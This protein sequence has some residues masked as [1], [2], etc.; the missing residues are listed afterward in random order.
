LIAADGAVTT[1]S[2][3]T[4]QGSPAPVLTP[5]PTTAS[6]PSLSRTTAP[7]AGG[8]PGGGGPITTSTQ[9]PFVP[10]EGDPVVLDALPSGPTISGPY[11]CRFME[12][13]YSYIYSYSLALNPDTWRDF[14]G[15]CSLVINNITVPMSSC[16]LA[17][18][19]VGDGDGVTYT[20][21]VRACDGSC[22]ESNT[23]TRTLQAP[24]EYS[25]GQ[26]QCIPPGM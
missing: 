10:H 14:A 2:L 8:G 20:Y 15:T 26:A 19:Y 16:S 21:G 17:S 7:P 24:I 23:I 9:P 13:C 4:P 11:M 1:L 3:D 6:Q 22:V 25:C 5:P 18:V 12:W